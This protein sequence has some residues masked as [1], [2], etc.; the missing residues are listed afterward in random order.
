MKQRLFQSQQV[1]NA[2]EGKVCHAAEI[3]CSSLS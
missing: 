1:M 2:M 3:K